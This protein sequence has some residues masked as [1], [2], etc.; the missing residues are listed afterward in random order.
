LWINPFK[1]N[2]NKKRKAFITQQI[3]QIFM[4]PAL[5]IISMS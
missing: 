4:F 3:N 2:M 1:F 5:S